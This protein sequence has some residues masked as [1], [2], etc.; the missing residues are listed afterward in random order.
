MVVS[1]FSDFLESQT[2]LKR[3]AGGGESRSRCQM[4]LRRE[5]DERRPSRVCGVICKLASRS[6]TNST[7]AVDRFCNHVFSG[8]AVRLM[9]HLIILAIKALAVYEIYY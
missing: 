8:N 4:V 5:V 2:C 9:N 1:P 3:E 7:P 6:C